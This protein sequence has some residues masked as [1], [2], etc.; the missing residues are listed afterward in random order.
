MDHKNW[1]FSVNPPLS[2]SND[3]LTPPPPRGSEVFSDCLKLEN[4]LAGEL[5]HYAVY[6]FAY[7]LSCG[8]T[9]ISGG[10]REESYQKSS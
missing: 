10:E 7:P 5:S 2:S 6:Y 3:K 8:G 9:E 4:S 1:I